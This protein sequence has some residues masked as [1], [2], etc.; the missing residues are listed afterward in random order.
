M[1]IQNLDNKSIFFYTIIVIVII[2]FFSR[3]S[4]ELNIVYGTLIA[5]L[6][7]WYLYKQHNENAKYGKEMLEKKKSYIKPQGTYITNYPELI[8]F[9]FSVQEFYV[10][11]P[12]SYNAMIRT[13]D[14]FLMIYE[15][16]QIDNSLVMY[17]YETLILMKRE[18]LNNFHA[19]IF[20]MTNEA[21]TTK[22]SE[23]L[24]LFDDILDEYLIKTKRIY[25]EYH[26]KVGMT[27]E[28]TFIDNGPVAKVLY[29]NLIDNDGFYSSN[30]LYSADFY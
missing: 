12:A 24:I 30:Q 4:I 17:N 8:D 5:G 23:N 29:D 25:D 14:K 2:F 6:V 18:I 15:E 22:L 7:F 9:L 13:L 27:N 16:I 20:G 26:F 11:N 3:I 10:S 1:D 28:T 19:M 21:L